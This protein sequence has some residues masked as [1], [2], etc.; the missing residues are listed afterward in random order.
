M[1]SYKLKNKQRED[2]AVRFNIDNIKHSNRYRDDITLQPNDI[3]INDS[4]FDM[5]VRGFDNGH[6]TVNI[7]ENIK[8]KLGSTVK[9]G[10]ITRLKGQPFIC[11][12][13]DTYNI[14]IK[15]NEYSPNWVA[16]GESY[17]P[18][19]IGID[20][21]RTPTSDKSNSTEFGNML[22]KL[23]TILSR[24]EYYKY[25]KDGDYFLLIPKNDTTIYTMRINY[26]E[27]FDKNTNKI[28]LSVD[29]IS[30]ELIPNIS[31][32]MSDSLESNQY[33]DEKFIKDVGIRGLVDKFFMQIQEY[34]NT[35]FAGCFVQTSYGEKKSLKYGNYK[36]YVRDSPKSPYNLSESRF[37]E[38]TDI[39][40][41]ES[42]S[43]IGRVW[44]PLEKE[45]FGRNYRSLTRYTETTFKQY[46]TLDTPFKRVKYVVDNNG[47]HIPKPWMTFS[48]YRRTSKPVIVGKQGENIPIDTF[49]R[50][51]GYQEEIYSPLCITLAT[52]IKS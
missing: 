24:G 32:R 22:Y 40:T 1:K 14:K 11:I 39:F 9:K 38:A 41:G 47:D 6:Y 19:C 16:L 27:W 10:T 12:P 34:Y 28:Y 33:S 50:I 48:I 23:P 15:P 31:F 49:N 21:V 4:N 13:S 18:K 46:P 20:T 44:L 36:L 26:R 7:P 42:V 2:I 45:V 29:A 17:A 25:F 51:G 35:N 52:Y 43:V 37:V 5:Y 3:A 8:Y 30:D